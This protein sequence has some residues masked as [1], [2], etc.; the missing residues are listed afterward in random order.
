M[1]DLLLQ[2]STT[3]DAVK[4]TIN[5][6]CKPEPF[7]ILAT[8]GF[9]A[10]LA[11]YRLWTKPLIAGAIG[12]AALTGYVASMADPNFILIVKKA[13]NVPI[14]M[15]MLGIAFFVWLALRQAALNDRRIERG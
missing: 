3:I 2:S 14:T 9:I 5:W 12:L 4:E 7:L 13:D 15:M 6:L 8:L 11:F 1:N 10:M